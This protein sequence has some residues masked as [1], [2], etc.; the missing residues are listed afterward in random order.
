M[1]LIMLQISE[2]QGTH[3]VPAWSLQR[4]Q[5]WFQTTEILL[6]KFT[7]ERELQIII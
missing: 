4:N 5:F 3:D 2:R 7:V 1:P 6:K